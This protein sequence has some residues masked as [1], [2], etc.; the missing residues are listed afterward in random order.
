MIDQ[1]NERVIFQKATIVTDKIGNHRNIWEDWFTCSA[2]A[3]TY[4]A[5][6]KEGEVVTEQQTVTFTVRWCRE[7]KVLTSTGYRVKFRDRIYNII[8]V[9]PMNYQKKSL[10]IRCALEEREK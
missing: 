4:E 10:K 8:S 2:Y 9:D 7:T 5:Q 1:L 6:E 3:S